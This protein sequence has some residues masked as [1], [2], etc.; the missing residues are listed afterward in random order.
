MNKTKRI[1]AYARSATL[2]GP[3]DPNS[4]MEQ[5]L[6]ISEWAEHNG[7]IMKSMLADYGH[8]G[9][10]LSRNFFELLDQ[11]KSEDRDFDAIVLTEPSRI[12]RNSILLGNVLHICAL[13]GV[14]VIFHK[15][16]PSTVPSWVKNVFA[17][18]VR[19]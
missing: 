5:L 8:G 13:A 19:K 6:S 12:A 11:V 7:H 3:N 4:C 18:V 14:E 16:Q 10:S 9:N 17:G 2:K 1:I 15:I